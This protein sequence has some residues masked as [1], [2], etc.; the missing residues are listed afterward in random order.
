MLQPKRS[1][2]RK[3][4]RGRRKGVA[5]RGS[6]LAFGEFGLKSLGVSWVSAKE[7][8]AARRAITHQLRRGGRVWIRIFPDKP[9]T[10][11]AAGHRMGGGKGEIDRYV[12]VVK[13]GRIL[14][15]VA[16]ADEKI[17]SE[18]FSRASAKL[19]VKTKFVKREAI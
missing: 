15:E 17:V 19:S 3:S 18:A 7:I 1:K 16:G 9:V 8:E 13:P 12:A 4:F 10:A 6:D 2:F 14:F 5:A 11:R